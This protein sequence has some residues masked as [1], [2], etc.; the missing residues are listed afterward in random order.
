M[1]NNEK[2]TSDIIFQAEIRRWLF[3]KRKS[4]GL[5]VKMI[6]IYFENE[7]KDNNHLFARR[8]RAIDRFELFELV[9]CK[10][11]KAPEIIG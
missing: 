2:A 6:C 7:R 8:N 10:V 5:S 4:K 1:K 3:F 11:L 9:T